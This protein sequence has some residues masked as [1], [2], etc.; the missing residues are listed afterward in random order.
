MRELFPEELLKF[1]LE[2]DLSSNSLVVQFE[3]MRI[4]MMKLGYGR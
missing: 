1:W 2:A 4:G 3:Q